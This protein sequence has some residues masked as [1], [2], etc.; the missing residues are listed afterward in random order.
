MFDR[1]GGG[2]I[3]AGEVAEILGG[4]LSKDITVWTDIINEVDQDGNGEIDY[5]EF[6]TMMQKFLKST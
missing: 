6:K 2:T 5:D 3:S 4:T 1:D